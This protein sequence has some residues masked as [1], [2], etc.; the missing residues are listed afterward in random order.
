MICISGREKC[1]QKHYQWNFKTILSYCV[2]ISYH[3]GLKQFPSMLHK[4]FHALSFI[5][6]GKTWLYKYA[7][8]YHFLFQGDNFTN[9]P[10]SYRNYT[11]VKERDYFFNQPCIDGQVG[12]EIFGKKISLNGKLGFCDWLKYLFHLLRGQLSGVVL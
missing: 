7:T 3:L 10:C 9:D 6:Q 1:K 8:N 4:T 11:S 5:R 12:E 2:N